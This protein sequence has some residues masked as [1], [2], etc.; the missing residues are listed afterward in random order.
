MFIDKI[1][2][3]YVT[4][5]FG[6]FGKNIDFNTIEWQRYSANS[7][8]NKRIIGFIYFLYHAIIMRIVPPC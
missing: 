8:Q 7:F 6:S 4:N 1:I 2:R 3:K 5:D